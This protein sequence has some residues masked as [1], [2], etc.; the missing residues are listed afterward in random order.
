MILGVEDA[1]TRCFDFKKMRNT[2]RNKDLYVAY[3]NTGKARMRV[4]RDALSKALQIYSVDG[5]V[6]EAGKS[7]YHKCK[8]CVGVG[9]KE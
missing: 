4:D 5:K 3:I 8:A 6:L 7:F 1:W 9:R 2:Y